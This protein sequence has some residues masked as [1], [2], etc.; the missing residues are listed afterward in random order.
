[1]REINK[2]E[3]QTMD[4]PNLTKMRNIIRDKWTWETGSDADKEFL[5]FIESELNT[6][7]AIAS[8][9][10]PY[11]EIIGES[12]KFN[13]AEL[14]EKSYDYATPVAISDD[15]AKVITKM[16]TNNIKGYSYVSYNDQD[17]GSSIIQKVES[18]IH[19]TLRA[20]LETLVRGIVSTELSDF[21]NRMRNDFRCQLDALKF[22]LKE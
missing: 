10:E 12:L 16:I 4:T 2:K 18:E 5:D 15:L 11:F 21:E 19:T 20:S 7:E 6:R 8:V 3:I 22:E 17:I 13:G 1:M 14:F 9:P